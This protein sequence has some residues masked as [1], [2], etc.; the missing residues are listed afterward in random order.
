MN[1]VWGLMRHG[2]GICVAA[3]V[4]VGSGGSQARIDASGAMPHTPVT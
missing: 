2:F 3:Q 4:L 1:M